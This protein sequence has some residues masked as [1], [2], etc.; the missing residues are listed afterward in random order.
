MLNNRITCD[1]QRI[2]DD[3]RIRDDRRKIDTLDDYEG[4]PSMKCNF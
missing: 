2:G 3:R 1:D 4:T